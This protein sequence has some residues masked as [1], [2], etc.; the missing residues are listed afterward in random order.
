MKAQIIQMI[1]RLRQSWHQQ[2]EEAAVVEACREAGHQ[3]RDRKLNPLTTLRIF[4]LQ[5]LYGNVACEFVPRLAGQKFSDSAYCEARQRVPLAAYEALLTTCTKRLAD[6]VR[7]TGRWLG[8][9]L[10]VIDGCN[11]SMPDV[12]QLARQFGYPPGQA[13]GCGFPGGHWLAVVHSATGLVL[14][15]IVSRVCSADMPRVP[16]AHR[17]LEA[18]DVVLGDTAFCSFAHFALLLARGAQGIFRMPKKFH[19]DFT[20]GRPAKGSGRRGQ[21]G[22]PT[23]RWVRSLG[24]EDQIVEWVR[25]SHRPSWLS[26]EDWLAL[27]RRMLMRELRYRIPRRGFRAKVVTLATTLLDGDLYAKQKLAEAYGLRWQIETCFGHLKTTM[28]MDVLRCKTVDGVLKELIMFLLAY[29]LVRITMLQAAKQQGVPVERISFVAAL[30]WLATARPNEVLPKLPTNPARPGRIEPR[31]RKR[32][33]KGP[34]P[35][36]QQPRSQ[37]KQLLIAQ[38]VAA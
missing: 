37:L 34:Y 28:H 25:P 3:W 29:N 24:K 17:E 16:E 8:H 33:P 21:K 15:A 38:G 11:F 1:E 36:L 6:C 18:G 26:R 30:R 22:Q 4:L 20:P 19:V 27:P 9:R 31:C 35:W 23:S 10:L 5:I 14:R 32:R 13:A 7:D 2:M 12:P